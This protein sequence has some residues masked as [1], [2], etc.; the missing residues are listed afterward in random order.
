MD[1]FKEDLMDRAAAAA[2]AASWFPAT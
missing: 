2:A 1:P